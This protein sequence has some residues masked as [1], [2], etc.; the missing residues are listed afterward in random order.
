MG[1]YPSYGRKKVSMLDKIKGWRNAFI[2]DCANWWKFWSSWLAVFW[3]VVVTAVWNSPETL[4]QLISAM[5]EEVR[6]YLS[7]LVLGVVAGLPIIIRLIKQQKL[8]AA[9]EAKKEGEG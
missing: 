6:A 4:N 7:P 5:P 1:L 3:G 8:V 2:E 9:I